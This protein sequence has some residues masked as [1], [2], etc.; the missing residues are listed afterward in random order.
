MIRKVMDAT[1]FMDGKEWDALRLLLPSPADLDRSAREYGAFTY[2]RGVRTADA[3]LRLCLM[4]GYSQLS[5]RTVAAYASGN[6]IAKISDVA[7]LGRLKNAH[8]WLSHILGNIIG[9][10]RHDQLTSKNLNRL[11]LVDGSS[12]S[13][14]GSKGTDFRLH[15]RYD[16]A[17]CKISWVELTDAKGAESLGRCSYAPGSIVVGDR[18]YA[19]IKGLQ[20]VRDCGADFLTRVGWRSLKLRNS[21]GSP[22]NLPDLLQEFQGDILD[23]DVLIG[24]PKKHSTPLP[25]R[26][27]ISRLALEKVAGAQARAKRS[28]N[29]K[30][31][32]EDP[33]TILAAS[34][35]ML[36]T[37][38]GK[39][40]ADA[41]EVINL[42]RHRWQIE[43]VFK[44]MKSLIKIDELPAHDPDLAKT[45]LLSK[46]IFTLL[47]DK[48]TR[49][50]LASF[51][52]GHRW[53]EKT[54]T[55]A[56]IPNRIRPSASTRRKGAVPP[57]T[58]DSP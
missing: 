57:S 21:D 47:T 25:A 29:R 15:L 20:H 43:L 18:G 27:V 32:A 2:P 23:I 46:L 39:G 50:I 9:S 31:Y 35:I 7:L 4:Y 19:R 8:R 14:P 24:D 38:L 42:Y 41:L 58:H 52:S 10:S 28:S 34:F 33:R 6:G 40:D 55:L 17:D 56:G 36:V 48:I 3:L 22:F 11:I 53:R 44:R 51:P 12:I 45:W 13:K 49:D 37:S 5:L 54:V 30:G 26:L 1:T 16:F